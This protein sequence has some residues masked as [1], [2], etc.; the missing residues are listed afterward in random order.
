M[1]VTVRLVAGIGFRRHSSWQ[2]IDRALCLALDT[3]HRQSADPATVM[4]V[5]TLA[6]KADTPALQEF[7]RRRS[8]PLQ[9]IAEQQLDGAWAGLSPSAARRHL[10][11]PGVAEPCALIAAGPG[12]YLLLPKI[13]LDGVSVALAVAV[14]RES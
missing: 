7:C 11:L 2:A 5:A 12:G 3:I 1:P 4:R 10:A 13:S 14:G 6:H 8:L 9:M